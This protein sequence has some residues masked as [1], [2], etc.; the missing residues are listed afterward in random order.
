MV[1]GDLAD[2]QHPGEWSITPL[3]TRHKWGPQ[4]LILGPALFIFQSDL[5]DGIKCILVKFCNSNKLSEEVNT[6]EW[7]ATLQKDLDKLE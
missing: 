1:G 5:E 3:P 4:G 7:R 6:W 2:L